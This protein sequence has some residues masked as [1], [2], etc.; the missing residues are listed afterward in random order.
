M[1]NLIALIKVDFLNLTGINKLLKETSKKEKSRIILM[2]LTVAISIGMLVFIA[3]KYFMEIGK[4]LST[5]GGL[6]I[7]LY[8][9]VIGSTA[10][11]FF[12]SLYKAQGFLFGQKDFDFLMALPLKSYTILLSKL[13]N[14]V[15]INYLV[16]IIVMVPP[17]IIYFINSN[18]NFLNVISFIILFIFVPFIP[19]VVA[20][21]I[22][23][24]I[25]YVSS[26]MKYKNLATII[27][28]FIAVILFMAISMN[29]DN[30][31]SPEALDVNGI[32]NMLKKAYLPSYYFTLAIKDLNFLYASN[33]ILLSIAVFSLFIYVFNKSFKVINSKLMETYKKDNYK[34][35]DLAESSQLKALIKKEMKRYFSSSVYVLNTFFGIVLL[36]IVS[37]IALFFGQDQLMKILDIPVAKDLIG[38]F[39]IV[40]MSFCVVMTCTTSSSISL[41]SNNLWILK[42]SPIRTID[43]FKSKIIFNLSLILPA[44]IINSVL[45]AIAFKATLI[46]LLWYLI[47]P[48]LY[49]ITVA[50]GG[51][52]INLYFPKLVWTSETVVVKQ[53][54]SSFLGVMLGMV[55]VVIPVISFIFLKI[56][57][58]NIFISILALVL[59]CIIFILC[60]ILK[61]KG[62]ELFNK[63]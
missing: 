6:E 30:S 16:E 28:S 55:I 17:A 24:I 25:S 19:I 49:G 2:F 32:C 27:M 58:I 13:L 45:L 47:I 63:L 22:A 29:L 41:E 10:L 40:I 35:K 42:S 5:V 3:S 50:I 61:N 8:F 52:I 23:F 36:T 33:F 38:N 53:S 60:N 57:N 39:V 48:T 9:G 12:T 26:R 1:S 4:L 15:V 34:M 56:K 46:Q 21:I 11:I 62:V 14:L 18:S 20:S 51:L 7:L 43:I 31:I 59:I 44:V 37:I 54:L